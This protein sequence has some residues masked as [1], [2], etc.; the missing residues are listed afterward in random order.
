LRRGQ[1]RRSV[2]KPVWGRVGFKNRTLNNMNKQTII[3][4]KHHSKQDK[5]NFLS[6]ACNAE[7]F[8]FVDS[9]P[10][11]WTDSK[12]AIIYG[13]SGCGKTHLGNIW[14]EIANA[15]IIT[16][17]KFNPNDVLNA[18]ENGENFF[19]DNGIFPDKFLYDIYNIC[20]KETSG[21]VL[22]SSNKHPKLWDIKLADAK[23]RLLSIKTIEIGLPDEDVLTGL[24]LKLFNDRQLKISPEVLN[25]ILLRMERSF[26][27]AIQTVEKLDNLSLQEKKNITIPMVKK[28]MEL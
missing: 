11:S 9:F 16:Q 23:S 24:L 26:L 27:S 28:W 17:N 4:F 10:T 8:K 19:I 25:Y 18:L 20:L 14:A 6:S 5:D 3:N 22:L 1:T 13:E 15:K 7:A 12:I 21:F 2:A